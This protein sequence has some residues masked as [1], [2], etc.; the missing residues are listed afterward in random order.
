MKNIQVLVLINHVMVLLNILFW[1]DILQKWQEI[2]ALR[3]GRCFV[4]TNYIIML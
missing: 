4:T 2:M 3:K 1:P